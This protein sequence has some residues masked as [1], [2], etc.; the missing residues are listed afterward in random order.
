LEL[1]EEIAQK[2]EKITYLVFG[3]I[4]K[5]VFHYKKPL[6]MLSFYLPVGAHLTYQTWIIK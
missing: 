2:G 3:I 4:T 1:I 6:K 5:L